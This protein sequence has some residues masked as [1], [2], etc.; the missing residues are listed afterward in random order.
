M[1][2]LDGVLGGVVGSAM[3]AIVA[4]VI[5]EHG[6]VQGIVAQFEKSGLGEKVK[7]WVGTGQNLPI[8]ADQIHQ[9]LGSDM[10]QKLAAQFGVQPQE[11]AQ[12]LSE[13]L[14]H[15]VDQATPGG[16]VPPPGAAAAPA[17]GATA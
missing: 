9:A 7:S 1:G 6:G 15:A 4:K 8:S 16:V 13:I 3:T 5:E 11:L 10:V 17:A 2:L 12:K 14:P